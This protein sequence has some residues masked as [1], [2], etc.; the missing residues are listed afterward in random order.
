M[1]IEDT[2]GVYYQ[3]AG[4][5][6]LDTVAAG[7]QQTDLFGYTERDKKSESLMNVMDKINNK[8]SRGTIWLASEGAKETNDWTMQR[9]FKSPNYTGDWDEL[10]VVN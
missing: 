2:S 10:L 7:G 3:K 5:M 4:G 1:L 9:N 8:Y 6:L